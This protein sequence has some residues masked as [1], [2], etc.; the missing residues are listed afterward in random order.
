MSYR[1]KLRTILLTLN[2]LVLLLP[3][4]GIAIFRLYESELIKQ[5]E[6]ELISQAALTASMFRGTYLKQVE[7]S[8]GKG[9]KVDLSTLGNE[10]SPS[11]AR[12]ATE[13]TP[14]LPQLDLASSSIKAPAP[15]AETPTVTPDPIALV[16]GSV[17]S[18]VLVDARKIVLSGIRIVDCNGIV[19]ATSNMEAGLSLAAREEVRKAL[20]G[21]PTTLLRVRNSKWEPPAFSSIS[22]RARM[23]VFVALPVIIED[24]VVGAV[25]A[26]RTP[27]DAPKAMFMIRTHLLKAAVALVLIVLLMTALTAYYINRPVKALI[28]QADQLKNGDGG[29]AEPLKNPGIQEVAQLSEAIALMA[30]TLEERSGYIKTFATNVSHEFK[31]P[32]TSIHGA[33]EILKDHFQTMS[34]VERE[35]FLGIIDSETGRLERLVRRLL[36]LAR[37]DTVTLKEERCDA[38][39]ILGALS[40]RYREQGVTIAVECS[41]S[42]DP[43][44]IGHETFESI[45]SNMIENA[46]QHGGERVEIQVRGRVAEDADGRMLELDIQDNGPGISAGNRDKVFR[47]F[48]TTARETGGSG[49]GLSIVQSLLQAHGGTISLEP[50][51]TGAY[52]KVRVPV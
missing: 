20:K 28:R 33:V 24:R 41:G 42:A 52:F 16:S 11:I 51:D 2:I 12:N 48:F 35:N 37:A 15:P 1:P 32:L 38:C 8:T 3:L 49:L 19:V 23:R 43:V 34:P 47:P 7:S 45:V 40:Q 30:T 31:T 25:I 10:L 36:D 29:G 17:L 39:A 26:A 9:R 46:R 21:E 18:P 44:K 5:T 27:L 13:L 50:S 14:L 4:G 22:R 6:S